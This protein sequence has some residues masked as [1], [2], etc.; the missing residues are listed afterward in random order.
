MRMVSLQIAKLGLSVGDVIKIQLV[1]SVGN[2]MVSSTGYALDAEI[3]LDDEIFL[4]NLQDNDAVN[5]LSHYRLTLPNLLT[6]TFTVPYSYENTNHDLLSLLNIG[7]FHGII[8]KIGNTIELDKIFLEKL[9][10]YFTGENPHFSP[11]QKD[12]VT[13]YE[14][15][16]D[17]V[18]ETTTTIDIMQ[19]MDNYLAT[20]G[21]E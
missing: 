8:I 2:I 5:R 13:L 15:Y 16:A 1:D 18:L 6:F 20:L 17:E 7:C 19:L 11:A 9:D 21:N 3:T 4:Y 10:L 14:Y 12:L